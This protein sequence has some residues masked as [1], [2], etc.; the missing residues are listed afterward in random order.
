MSLPEQL[1]LYE[2]HIEISLIFFYLA[3][4]SAFYSKNFLEERTSSRREKEK[5]KE[6]PRGGGKSEGEG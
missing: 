4:S 5:E 6:A 2:K 1:R 3:S